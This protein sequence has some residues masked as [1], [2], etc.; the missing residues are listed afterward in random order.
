MTSEVGHTDTDNLSRYRRRHL[1]DRRQPAMDLEDV[2][3]D[4]D[5]DVILPTPVDR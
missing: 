5:S 2:E 3:P 4:S 1:N